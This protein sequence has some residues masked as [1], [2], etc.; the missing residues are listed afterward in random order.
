MLIYKCLKPRNINELECKSILEFNTFFGAVPKASRKFIQSP[1][2]WSIGRFKEH[3]SDKYEFFKV[4]MFKW[5]F[6][7]KPDLVIHTSHN[8]AVC[9]EAK[10]M[11]GE[12][13]YPTTPSEKEEFKRRNLPYMHQTKLQEYMMEELLG[14]KTQYIYL[15]K[16]PPSKPKDCTVLLWKEAFA[17][18]KTEKC[19]PFV[20]KWIKLFS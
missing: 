4:C 13:H 10:F 2:N 6:N 12:G 15:V 3:I 18:L 11:S 14:I 16:K 20:K 17:C 9:I 19:P 5:S 7:A 8:T 1:G